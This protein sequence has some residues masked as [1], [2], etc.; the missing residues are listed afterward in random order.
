MYSTKKIF[1]FLPAFFAFILALLSIV[2]ISNASIGLCADG[3]GVGLEEKSFTSNISNDNDLPEVGN[4]LYTV[5]ELFSNSY[6][7]A[8]PYGIIKDNSAKWLIGNNEEVSKGIPNLE[9]E[10]EERLKKQ[11]KMGMACSV[12]G[13]NVMFSNLTTSV[14]QAMSNLTKIFATSLFRDD[15]VCKEG[16]SSKACINLLGVIGGKSDN[17]S[18]GLISI[19]GKGLFTPLLLLAFIC[20]AIW[21]LYKGIIKREFRATFGGILWSLFALLLGSIVIYNPYTFARAPQ[22]VNSIISDCLLGA[23]TGSGCGL[24]GS[25]EIKI[26]SKANLCASESITPGTSSNS[27]VMKINSLSCSITKAFTINRWSYEQFGYSIDELWTKD[28]PDGY[29]VYPEKKLQGEPGDF[30]VNMYSEESPSKANGNPNMTGQARCNIALAYLAKTTGG[31]Y[32]TKASLQQIVLTAAKD[33]TMWR[34]FSGKAGRTWITG[35]VNNIAVLL[36][37]IAFIP[38][39]VYA[40][41]YSLTSTILMAFSPIFFLFAIVPGKGKKI[42][43]GWLEAII[44]NILKYLAMAML[45]LVM[46]LLYGAS[47]SNLGAWHALIA[48]IILDATFI[49]YR[50]EFANLIGA[51]NMGG[52]KVANRASNA[53]GKIQDNTSQYAKA[54]LGGAFGG[55][56][57][58]SDMKKNGELGGGKQIIANLKEAGNNIAKGEFTKAA[59]NVGEAGKNLKNKTLAGQMLQGATGGMGMEARRGS[60]VVATGARQYKMTR[61][62]LERD[63]KASETER[64]NEE[65]EEKNRLAEQKSRT[66]DNYQTYKLTDELNDSGLNSLTKDLEGTMNDIN[67][68]D[69][70]KDPDKLTDL[71]SKLDIKVEHT[72]KLIDSI[73]TVGGNKLGG[74]EKLAD[75]EAMKSIN[76]TDSSVQS[77]KDKLQILENS[78]GINKDDY[79][80]YNNIINNLQDKAI[81]ESNIKFMEDLKNSYQNGDINAEDFHKAFEDFQGRQTQ[82]TNELNRL[83]NMSDLAIKSFNNSNPTTGSPQPSDSIEVTVKAPETFRNSNGFKGLD[84]AFEKVQNN[85]NGSNVRETIEEIRE[86]TEEFISEE[87]AKKILER[88]RRGREIPKRPRRQ[89]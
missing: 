74:L 38:V 17:D 78:G 87:D 3:L 54:G 58:A 63:R 31:Y 7:N 33:D 68:Y 21:A 35:I 26:D 25:S 23:L 16:S 14:S 86:T 89:K 15:F 32:G 34:S 18:K 36:V 40:H 52:E 41:A 53:L 79:N 39:T 70:H 29:D 24:T 6:H 83:H 77:L 22:T 45:T 75:D 73:N 30:C 71:Q 56:L 69:N 55:A 13:F 47:L 28:P 11:G 57:L 85:F 19:F 61:D 50:K 82:T 88:G 46:I 65:Q 4:R 5:D 72:Q 20:V 42:F 64:F 59:T 67:D 12:L 1:L 62:K 76:R 66:A 44:G 81:S 48:V 10:Q 80:K 84:N 51:V 60:G 49:M 27:L 8:T 43:L 37:A 2:N 9:K